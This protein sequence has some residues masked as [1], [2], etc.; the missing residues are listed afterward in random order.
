MASWFS[1]L[2]GGSKAA[3]KKRAD[4]LM[5]R[6]N[7]RKAGVRETLERQMRPETLRNLAELEHP[8]AKPPPRDR[9]QEIFDKM[10]AEVEKEYEFPDVE[11][12]PWHHLVS[13]NVDAIRYH[14]PS[15]KLQVRFK[16]GSVYEYDE[17]PGSVFME[18]LQ[19]HSPGQFRW[20]VLGDPRSES[21]IHFNYRK[22][23]GGAET[24]PP[25]PDRFSGTPFRISAKMQKVL[26]KRPGTGATGMY[27][28]GVKPPPSSYKG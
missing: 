19:T 22:V 21:G 17:V 25:A 15:K 11:H 8:R 3:A 7:R 27:A 12:E 4:D 26:K 2:Y 1:W 9:S 16:D 10:V 18:F 28:R 13:S 23:G 24:L 6:V 20:Y 5:G 14:K